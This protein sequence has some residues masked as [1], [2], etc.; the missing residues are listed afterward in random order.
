[1]PVNTVED[2]MA[3]FQRSRIHIEF[4]ASLGYKRLCL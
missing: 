3:G 4:E 2:W 1:M